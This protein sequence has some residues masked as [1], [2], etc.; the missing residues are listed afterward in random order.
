MLT[1][2][3]VVR[4]FDF[5]AAYRQVP[6]HPVAALKQ[7]VK[8]KAGATLYDLCTGFGMKNAGNMWD[9]IGSLVGVTTCKLLVIRGR[10]V[11]RQNRANQLPR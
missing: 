2:K 3:I 11:Q 6:V 7:A 10:Y 4:K 8:T 1:H 5:K 9:L